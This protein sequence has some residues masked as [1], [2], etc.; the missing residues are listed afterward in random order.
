M[1]SRTRQ[2]DRQTHTHR[3]ADNQT[4]SEC[5]IFGCDLQGSTTWWEL[6]K[7]FQASY[8]N[9]Y[10]VASV[11]NYKSLSQLCSNGRCNKNRWICSNLRWMNTR[12]I[13]SV[14]IRDQTES[15]YSL[16]PLTICH[17]CLLCL[18]LSHRAC[19]YHCVQ[20]LQTLVSCMKSK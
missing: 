14:A 16:N 2:T 6:T 3:Q 4:A 8:C 20:S 7:Q 1:T 19:V 9:G 17:L 5:N 13:G 18:L 11:K 15:S 12:S 10:T